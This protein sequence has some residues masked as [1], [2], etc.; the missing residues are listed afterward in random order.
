MYR[1][2]E[3]VRVE[4]TNE[5]KQIKNV[6]DIGDKL[7]YVSTDNIWFDEELIYPESMKFDIKSSLGEKLTL[8]DFGNKEDVLNECVDNFKNMSKDEFDK[9]LDVISKYDFTLPDHEPKKK[10]FKWF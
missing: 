2:G 4:G 5:L 9:F 1:K 10:R 7:F 3:Y 8:S 6:V